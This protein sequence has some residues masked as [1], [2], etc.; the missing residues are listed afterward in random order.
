VNVD[1]ESQRGAGSPGLH[2]CL[3]IAHV[4]GAADLGINGQP[5]QSGVAL[6]PIGQVRDIEAA[7]LLKPDQQ[8][9]G[10]SSRIEWP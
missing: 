4:A 7:V 5:G 2:R 3:H 1:L 10:R 6:E 9:R 8:P